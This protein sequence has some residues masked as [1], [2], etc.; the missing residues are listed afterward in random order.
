MGLVEPIM[1]PFPKGCTF[2]NILYST[3]FNF[4]S[5]HWMKNV[6]PCVGTLNV[7]FCKSLVM[8]YPPFFQKHFAH[9][10]I[11]FLFS[12]IMASSISPTP[13]SW[14]FIIRCTF[15][16]FDPLSC[17]CV[18]RVPELVFSYFEKQGCADRATLFWHI[19]FVFTCLPFFIWMGNVMTLSKI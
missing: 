1:S 16:R 8:I 6:M 15:A 12:F 4:T 11:D 7:G 17:F 3:P 18:G 19:I 9:W 13:I 14:F 2:C 10:L 5:S